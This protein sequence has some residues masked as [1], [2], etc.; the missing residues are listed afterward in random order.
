MIWYLAITS[1][2]AYKNPFVWASEMAHRVKLLAPKIANLSSIPETQMEITDSHNL[3]SN[4]HMVV[5][6]LLSSLIC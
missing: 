6:L 5:G 4:F 1:E 3:F 2:G